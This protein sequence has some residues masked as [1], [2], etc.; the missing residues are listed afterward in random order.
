[1][2]WIDEWRA[3]AARSNAQLVV[4]NM[5]MQV[6]QK[7]NEDP[8]AMSAT[9]SAQVQ[10]TNANLRTFVT[11]HR[12]ILPPTAADAIDTYLQTADQKNYIAGNPLQ[13]LASKLVKL[14]CLSSEVEYHLTDFAELTRRTSER[15]FLHLQQCIVANSDTQ[16]RWQTAFA[17]H[18]TACEKLGAAHLLLHGIYAFKIDAAGGR[19]DL[20]FMDRPIQDM[21]VARVADALVLTEWKKV[22]DKDKPEDKAAEA[23][24]E[25]QRYQSGILSGSELAAYR[26]IV[27]VSKDW[28]PEIPDH[29]VHEVTYRHINIAVSPSTPS[30]AARK[31][32]GSGQNATT[33][34]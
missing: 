22:K 28:L 10:D 18:E 16:D 23:R 8:L 26:Y 32:A 17:Q 20:V 15:A 19:T 24:N 4:G 13:M 7:N 30:V 29:L 12:N 14:L 9:L 21:E 27:L 6:F 5:M 2:T 3:I 11:R 34:P 25:A 1:M 33:A 31:Q